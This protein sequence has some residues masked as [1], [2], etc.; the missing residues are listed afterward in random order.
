MTIYWYGPYGSSCMGSDTYIYNVHWWCVGA[1]DA[2]HYL[3]QLVPADLPGSVGVVLI[4]QLFHLL[5]L[6]LRQLPPLRL[7]G[8][9]QGVKQPPK[10]T[11]PHTRPAPPSASSPPPARTNTG[12][13]NNRHNK[14]THTPA[15]LPRQLPA[16]RLQAQTQGVTQLPKQ[17]PNSPTERPPPPPA[18]RSCPS[19]H[20]TDPTI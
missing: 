9:T 1:D 10:E 14:H 6:L 12:C 11:Q 8:Q 20:H 15:L 4:E 2:L 19:A 5:L 18:Q 13:L 17:T 7:Q 16:L 3:V